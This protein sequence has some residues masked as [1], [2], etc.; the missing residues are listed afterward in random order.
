M[1][2]I[3]DWLY[4]GDKDDAHRAG[5]EDSVAAV[6]SLN[7][8]EVKS[9]GDYAASERAYHAPMIDGEDNTEKAFETAIETVFAALQEHGEVLVHCSAGVSRSGTVV[10]T[11]LA[12]E[13]GLL[14]AEALSEVQQ[15]KPNVNPHTHLEQQAY[16]YLGEE[17]PFARYRD[18]E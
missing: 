1:Y 14:F 11:V 7:D 16:S 5:E 9:W 13:E 6:V 4:I 17:H 15:V 10:A 8:S 2:Q 12:Q 3:R 18:N